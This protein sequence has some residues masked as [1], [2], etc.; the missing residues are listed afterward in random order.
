VAIIV[1]LIYGLLVAFASLRVVIAL[2]PGQ[3]DKLG[4][5][6]IYGVFSILGYFLVKTPRAYQW[7]CV[8]IILYSGLMEV[9]QS[10]V[11]GRVP[12]GYDLIANTLGVL[13]GAVL[14]TSMARAIHTR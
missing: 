1:F 9:A 14:V 2:P 5:F 13:L 8:S 4:H 12:S 3:W 10:Y 6:L 11:P 7:V